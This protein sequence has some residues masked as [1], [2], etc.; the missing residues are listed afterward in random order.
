M[1]PT[2]P[3]TIARDNLPAPVAAAI[4]FAANETKT[5]PG[6]IGLLDYVHE[7]WSDSSL[8]CP[9]PGVFYTQ[10]ITPGDRVGLLIDDRP[11]EYHTDMFNRVVRCDEGRGTRDGGRDGRTG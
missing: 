5:P 10:V 2:P 11:Y 6:E 1:T 8:G 9:Q 3:P 7:E 4:E